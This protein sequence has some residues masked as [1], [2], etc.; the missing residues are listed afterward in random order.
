M[1]GLLSTRFVSI[2]TS[3]V[4]CLT[5]MCLTSAPL[6]GQAEPRISFTREI[7]PL[8]QEQCLRCHSG[9]RPRAGLD[10]SQRASALKGGESEVPAIVPGKP[11]ESLLFNRVQAKRMPPRRPLADEQIHL[12]ERW[13][14]QGA[15]WEGAA[16][17]VDLGQAKRTD[18]DW[19][20]FQPVR[21]PDLPQVD[22]RQWLRSPI[23]AFILADLEERG[24]S[25]SP[26][27]ER[28]TLIRRLTLDLTGLLPTPEEV[29]AFA[30][31]PRP[32]AYERLVDRLLASPA[33]GE[34]WARHWL[35]V[36]RFAESHGYEMNT[37]RQNAWPYRDFVVRAFNEDLPYPEFV[38]AQL[39]GDVLD[40]NDPLTQAATGFLVGGPH[41]MV[42]NA[43]LEGKLQQRA[44]DLFDMV[45]TTGATFLGLTVGC[46]RC[47][48][49]K[50][51]PIT[52]E[53]FYGLE[54]I[55]AGVQHAERILPR[56]GGQEREPQTSRGTLASPHAPLVAEL[57]ARLQ[58]IEQRLLQS[59]PLAGPPG[60]EPHRPALN[61]RLNSERF[62]PVKIR[63]LRFTISATNDGTEPCIDE[64]ELLGPGPGATNQA[65]A[66]R[67]VKA[68]ASSVYA[69][70]PKH[71]LAHLND[72]Q[73]G[74]SHSWISRERGK[75][76]VRLDL[77]EP[78]LIS[79]VL[80]GR[81][82][83]RKYR[84]R[85]PV[86]YRVEVSRDG[87]TWET[88]A[89]SW[90]RLPPG[91]QPPAP[92]PLRAEQERLQNQLQE[93]K[94]P[95]KVYAGTFREP[96]PTFLLER[97]NP[98]RKKKQV[99]PS[100]IRAIAPA[101]HLEPGAKE[102]ERR[103]ALA[104]WIN[105]PDNPLTARVLV[106]RIWQAHFG[107]G[108]VATP[109]DFG[110]NGGRPSHPQ[111]LDWLASEF[112]RQGRQL[113]PL[114]RLIVL[115]ATYRQASTFNPRAAAVDG[116]GRLLWR[117]PRRRLEAEA[118]RDT[119][120]EVSGSLRRRMGGPGYHLWDYS[121][122]VIVF[123]AKPALGPDTFRR[124]IYQFKPRL[125]QDPVFGAFDCPD[126]TQMM[127]RRNVSTTPLQAL[128]LFNAPFVLD[129]SER[130]ADRLREQAGDDAVAQVR[131]AFRIAFGRI[132]SPGEESAARAVVESHGL[133]PLC[134]ALFNAN[135]FVFM[136]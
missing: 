107:Q 30:T 50:F 134:R 100:A 60:T 108:I 61:P 67:G 126:A 43:T 75:G 95:W 17:K 82:R 102:A 105:H 80:W 86:D 19:W 2:R 62:R 65:L 46:A 20:A 69:N 90:D 26:E 38:R 15:P 5:L 97:G 81:D 92:S 123:K 8:L 39:A 14:T 74:N 47:H 13:I 124:M 119:M 54:A 35:D 110:T 101:F 91:K 18:Q 23:D 118:L 98:M 57:T 49:H 27:A 44:D 40:R 94:K 52:Q 99:A 78:A 115:S 131:L 6:P 4:C 51:D 96:G 106:N 63:A 88:V 3:V 11:K 87:T 113:K 70:N 130:F 12:L 128:N 24:L 135:E 42:G 29:E 21:R 68:S 31:D 59:E 64:L 53:D 114:H 55:F 16:L 45:N 72:G 120:L 36:V 71:Q 22:R 34:R 79:R 122:Y 117:Y 133:V 1:P 116:L 10:L 9:R 66:K 136:D 103:L 109:S 83:E 48:D 77:P 121:G 85:L 37:L 112:H 73:V 28:R 58:E 89:G 127:P 129:Q 125:Q 25:P 111:L 76:W 56:P 132:P 104:R 32:D 7:A 41:D 84:D 33:Y 93:L